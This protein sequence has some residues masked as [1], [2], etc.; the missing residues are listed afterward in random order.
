MF[1]S[2]KGP[3]LGTEGHPVKKLYME[4]HCAF[5]DLREFV[6]GKIGQQLRLL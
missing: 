4:M 6:T 2:S 5:P 1:E 3:H